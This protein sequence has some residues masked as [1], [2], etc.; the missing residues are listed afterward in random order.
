MYQ[1]VQH[2]VMQS[3][4]LKPDSSP[5]FLELEL[6]TRDLELDNWKM[7]GLRTGHEGTGLATVRSRQSVSGFWKKSW[8]FISGTLACHNFWTPIGRGLRFG[9]KVTGVSLSLSFKF[10]QLPVKTR[11]VIHVW[12]LRF[13]FFRLSAIF[14]TSLWAGGKFDQFL[15]SGTGGGKSLNVWRPLLVS[16]Y[17]RFDDRT[18]VGNVKNL[19]KAH[20]RIKI[21]LQKMFSQIFQDRFSLKFFM[22]SGIVDVRSQR[23]WHQSIEQFFFWSKNWIFF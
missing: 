13:S 15:V 5:M 16:A 11:R 20:F 17:F 9:V 3:I 21:K 12:N 19:K 2:N 6:E 18:K 23:F 4:V 7:C 8:N 10:E 14:V 22:V 1:P